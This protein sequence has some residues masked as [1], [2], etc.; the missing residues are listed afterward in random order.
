MIRVICQNVNN[1][2]NSILFIPGNFSIGILRKSSGFGVF[3]NIFSKNI[4]IPSREIPFFGEAP[5]QF[6]VI[7]AKFGFF[8]VLWM[9]RITK[10]G[11]IWV[12]QITE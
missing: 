8:C 11:Y 7:I 9:T 5:Q 3:A 2:I 6:W 10:F 12:T 4:V 1:N